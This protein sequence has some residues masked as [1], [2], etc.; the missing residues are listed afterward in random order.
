M[1]MHSRV[2]KE[3]NNIKLLLKNSRDVVLL[4]SM[5]DS[6]FIAMNQLDAYFSMVAIVE[7]IKKQELTEA[8]VN[9]LL[10]WLSDIKKTNEANISSLVSSAQAVDNPTKVAVERMKIIFSDLNKMIEA[11]SSR[12]TILRAGI[13]R[14]MVR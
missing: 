6:C 12:L 10:S 2:M 13:T 8:A 9:Y 4:T 7:T 14:K 3:S 1:N 11:E 5:W